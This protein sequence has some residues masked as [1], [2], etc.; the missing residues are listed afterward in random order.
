MTQEEIEST[1]IQIFKL[2]QSNKEDQAVSLL[3]S[4]VESR[5]TLDKPP[6]K[7]KIVRSSSNS[8]SFSSTCSGVEGARD[9]SED[10]LKA[11]DQFI[12]FGVDKE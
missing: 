1:V 2:T 12:E 11:F 7:R 10:E 4:I 9:I 8:N 6:R 5:A 3:F